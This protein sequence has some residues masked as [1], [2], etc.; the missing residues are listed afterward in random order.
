MLWHRSSR[1]PDRLSGCRGVRGTCNGSRDVAPDPSLNADV[2]LSLMRWIYIIAVCSLYVAGV[3]AS[4][5]MVGAGDAWTVIAAWS[6]AFVWCFLALLHGRPLTA[7][8]IVMV[9]TLVLPIGAVISVAWPN[10]GLLWPAFQD[11]GAVGGLQFFAPLM[12]ALLC[13]LLARRQYIRSAG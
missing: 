12:V 2:T 8:S 6:A 5:P 3:L 13:A 7:V 1:R 9:V 11:R 10:L 4:V